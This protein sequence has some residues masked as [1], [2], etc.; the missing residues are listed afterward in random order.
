MFLKRFS[1]ISEM[2]DTYTFSNT[3][4]RSPNSVI[5]SSKSPDSYSNVGS[6]E[7]L[8]RRKS[9]NIG[10]S[11]SPECTRLH[12]DDSP[13]SAYGGVNSARKHHPTTPD[14]VN[15]QS[16]VITVNSGHDRRDGESRLVT[17]DTAELSQIIR[18]VIQEEIGA[19]KYNIGDVMD[20]IHMD[21]INLQAEIILNL[22]EQHVR[23]TF[24]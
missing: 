21:I 4:V 17:V 22:Q 14:G 8:D 6:F 3:S 1:L 12:L 16:S 20:Q 7:Q 23:C 19:L 2:P 24:T 13:G 9:P 15:A 10:T 11:A 5:S 18:S